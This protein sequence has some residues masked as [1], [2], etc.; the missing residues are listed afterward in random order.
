MPGSKEARRR[1]K[2]GPK[3]NKSVVTEFKAAPIYF[4]IFVHQATRR[5]LLARCTAEPNEA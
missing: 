5:I 3:N 2:R 4:L 1:L